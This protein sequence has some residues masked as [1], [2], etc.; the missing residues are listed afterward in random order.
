MGQ[1]A[2]LSQE[3]IAM[4]A[5]MHHGTRTRFLGPQLR[6]KEAVSTEVFKRSD[7]SMVNS[8]GGKTWAASPHKMTRSLDHRLQLRAENRNGRERKT[9][10]Q[11]AGN[12]MFPATLEKNGEQLRD[13]LDFLL[14]RGVG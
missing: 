7:V 5:R 3:P 6:A 14:E 11:S 8:H 10:M 1:S 12:E 13:V 9:L 4:Q 2:A